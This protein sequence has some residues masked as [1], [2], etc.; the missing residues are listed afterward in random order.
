MNKLS[1]A[2]DDFIFTLH[3]YLLIHFNLPIIFCYYR[4]IGYFTTDMF[5][6]I[7]TKKYCSSFCT[8]H[9]SNKIKLYLYNIKTII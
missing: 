3:K 6:F 9:I 1:L 4:D 5:W 2:N 8:C 7:S